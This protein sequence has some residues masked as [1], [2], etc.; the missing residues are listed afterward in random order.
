M[1]FA[2][3]LLASPSPPLV[4]SMS[5][6]SLEKDEGKQSVNQTNSAYQKLALIGVT[7][8]A[9]SGDSGACGQTCTQCSST[10]YPGYPADSP[11]VLSVGATELIDGETT[12]IPQG[13]EPSVCQLKEYTCAAS[14]KE[15]PASSAPLGN[16]ATGGG[17]SIYQSMVCYFFC[18]YFN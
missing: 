4:N 7:M 8:V 14:G 13:D 16:Y 10:F 1:D 3:D 17:F 12:E 6:L 5:W 15:D 9:S 2:Q 11:W 18:F